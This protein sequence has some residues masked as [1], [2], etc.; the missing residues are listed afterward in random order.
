[1]I[2]L[3]RLGAP[4]Q[5]QGDIRRAAGRAI[6]VDH[7]PGRLALWHIQGTDGIHLGNAGFV[8]AIATLGGWDVGGKAAC[9][10]KLKRIQ[11]FSDPSET[12]K[13]K[14]TVSSASRQTSSGLFQ[15]GQRILVIVDGGQDFLGIGIQCLDGDIRSF[16]GRRIE[17]FFSQYDFAVAIQHH[18]LTIRPGQCQ[19]RTIFQYEA[20][21]S[22]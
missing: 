8:S 17:H 18:G 3:S 7:K 6:Q 21:T 12:D 20:L 4:S 1:M 11:G 5:R 14:A 15:L 16:K 13:A 9:W 2:I 22:Q 10:R 19:H